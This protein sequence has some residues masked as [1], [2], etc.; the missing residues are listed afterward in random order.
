MAGRW[1][2]CEILE[3]LTLAFS[4]NADALEKTLASGELRVRR[5]R[6][7]QTAG[8]ILVLNLGHFPKVKA[9][10]MTVPSGTIDPA[11]S[12]ATI[13]AAL[14][15]V[16]DAL[17]RVAAKF[18]DR[19]AVVNHPYFAGLSVAQWRKL[20]SAPHPSPHAPGQMDRPRT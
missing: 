9:P 2:I 1:S 20:H 13:R 5:P 3:H 17:S 8:R 10:V 4:A 18:G 11:A 14:V 16:D 6:L 19:V 7:K 12:L 15:R